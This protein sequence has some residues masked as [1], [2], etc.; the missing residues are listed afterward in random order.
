MKTPYKIITLFATIAISCFTACSVSD[1]DDSIDFSLDAGSENKNPNSEK[2]T[3]ADLEFEDNYDILDIYYLNRKELGDAENYYNKGNVQNYGSFADVYYMYSKMSDPM[4]NYYDPQY[5]SM[6][7]GSLLNSE[8]T[9]G[10]GAEASFVK[11]DEKDSALVISQVLPNSPAEK[12]KIQVGDT[13]LSVRG[14]TPANQESFEALAS[15]SIGQVIDISLK[16]SETFDVKVRVEQFMLPTVYVNYVENIPVIRITDFADYTASDSGSYGEFISALNAT[17]GAKAT[18]LDLRGNGGGVIEH[19]V[20][21]ASEILDKGDTIVSYV[22]TNYD[23]TTQ[24]QRLDTLTYEAA[25]KGVGFDRYY[26]ILA[27]SNSASCSE[28]FISAV[29]TNRRTPIVGQTTY[30]K[31]I[32]QY[33]INTVAGGLAVVTAMSGFDKDWKTF[34]KVGILPDVEENDYDA[35]TSKAIKLAQAMTA[36]RQKGYGTKDKGHFNPKTTSLN[37]K[38][39]G[40]SMPAYGTAAIVKKL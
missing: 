35:A 39:S 32:G 3:I 37:K 40:V 13:V 7:L 21:M 2:T 29:A 4:T 19:C 18:V 31:G 17:K 22:M 30:G 23:S 8:S 9:L 25:S 28:T 5:S 34:H 6:V 10:I 20:S 15:G 36:T 16:R 24:E 33:Y 14:T 26:V 12:A 38:A 1:S 27:D 11:V